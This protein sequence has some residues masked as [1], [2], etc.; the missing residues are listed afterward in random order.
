MKEIIDEPYSTKGL[1]SRLM[2]HFGDSVIIADRGGCQDNLYLKDDAK[3]LLYEF[4]RQR[5]LEQDDDQKVRIIKLAA[6]LI[7]S[8]IKDLTDKI[9]IFFSFGHFNNAFLCT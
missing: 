9:D 6:D 2:E 3:H 4:Y 8:D 7:R 1:K 5:E